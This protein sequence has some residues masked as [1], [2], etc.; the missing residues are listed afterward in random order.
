MLE[1][2][3]LRHLQTLA[4][5]K[6]SAQEEANL[7]KQLDSI[8]QFLGQLDQ[9]QISSPSSKTKPE[10]TLRTVS[11]NTAFPD[12][13]DLLRNVKHPLTNNSIVIKSALG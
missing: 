13:A 8:I 9:I 3:E 11:G 2:K 6:L 5:I 1:T 12:T 10:L 7:G 4:N